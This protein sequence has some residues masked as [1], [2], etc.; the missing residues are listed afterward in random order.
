MH[1]GSKWGTSSL[2]EH[3]GRLRMFLWQ[4]P[5]RAFPAWIAW[6]RGAYVSSGTCTG[7]PG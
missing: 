7:N 6:L 4:A 1:Q 5:S 2:E 3:E